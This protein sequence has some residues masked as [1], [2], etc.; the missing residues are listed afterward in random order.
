MQPIRLLPPLPLHSPPGGERRADFNVTIL[1]SS[2]SLVSNS[3]VKM[4]LSIYLSIYHD[5]QCGDINA[6]CN[7]A[8]LLGSAC[9]P[10]RIH[11]EPTYV[12]GEMHH[13]RLLLHCLT[14]K[15]LHR[16]KNLA[17]KK[18]W[19]VTLWLEVGCCGGGKGRSKDKKPFPPDQ[20]PEVNC[21]WGCH[22][23]R[24]VSKPY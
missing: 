12:G 4:S 22:P 10:C 5:A 19:G 9:P 13:C 20:P 21:F 17:R 16:P 24:W 2:Y 14:Q 23:C 7:D 18:K 15:E 11:V 3:Y 6:K 1:K 8:M